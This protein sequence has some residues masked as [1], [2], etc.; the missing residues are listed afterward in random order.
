MHKPLLL[1]WLGHAATFT[2]HESPMNPTWHS[3]FFVTGLHMPFAPHGGL[4]PPDVPLQLG[5]MNPGV[6]WQV[7]SVQVPWPEQ[8]GSGHWSCTEQSIPDQPASQTQA[9]GSSQVP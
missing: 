8:S 1:Q 2:V 5:P 3:H 7:P 9:P 4:Q 6:Q